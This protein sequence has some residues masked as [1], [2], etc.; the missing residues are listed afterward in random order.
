MAP[1]NYYHQWLG[2]K[3]N[4]QPPTLYQLLG[5]SQFENDRDVIRNATER[6][7]LHV[8]R[9]A[10]GP[11]TEIG[12][13]LLNELA[14]AKLTLLDDE[15]RN[16]YDAR[17][18]QESLHE[19]ESKPVPAGEQSSGKLAPG[20]LAAGELAPGELAPGELAPGEKVDD[21][22]ADDSVQTTGDEE[23]ARQIDRISGNQP[24][25]NTIEEPP[26]VT[27][28]G[29]LNDR[30]TQSTHIQLTRE[31]AKQ[32]GREGWVIGYNTGCHFHVDCPVVSNVHCKFTWI[33]E[34]LSLRDLNS[35]N[36]TFVNRRKIRS[37]TRIRLTD[38]VTLGRDHRII[39]PR[40][41]FDS[42]SIARVGAFIFV[43]QG[44]GNELRLESP[45]VSTYHARLD[46]IQDRIVVV[47]LNSTN[48]TFVINSSGKKRLSEPYL[49][50]KND[51]VCFGDL[52]LEYQ[53]MFEKL[54][55]HQLAMTNGTL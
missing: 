44:S 37:V 43:G 26:N 6:Q 15:K 33:A 46:W 16:A 13:A 49:L 38:L 21:Q 41:L 9:L 19:S 31:Q 7:S 23:L 2:I 17:L 32:S 50:S 55:H 42:V 14:E 54:I 10:R 5:I 12:Q 27:S 22:Q 8:R 25:G 1:Y 18:R 36:G 3:P 51:R 34:V 39:F 24:T 30:Q 35:T 48:G 4:D 52:T 11:F 47:D 53:D 29:R 28:E 45:A 40:E 20:E